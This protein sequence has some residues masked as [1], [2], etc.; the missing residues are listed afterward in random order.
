MIKDCAKKTFHY[1]LSKKDLFSKDNPIKSNRIYNIT[2]AIS[3]I[4]SY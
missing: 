3:D 4:N 2:H 1:G